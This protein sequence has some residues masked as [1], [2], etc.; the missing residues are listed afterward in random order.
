MRELAWGTTEQGGINLIRVTSTTEHQRTAVI[1]LLKS[2]VA[3]LI[4]GHY[5]HRCAVADQIGNV[6]GPLG[7]CN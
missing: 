6:P 5:T 7:N 1:L 3:A 4:A 2:M